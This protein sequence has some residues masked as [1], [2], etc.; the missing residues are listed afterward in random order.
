LA[1]GLPQVLDIAM[2]SLQ[3]RNFTPVLA[4]QIF[5]EYASGQSKSEWAT[6]RSD[7]KTQ[8]E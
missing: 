4:K 7:A 6:R 5:F 8:S 3:S 1:K 2:V